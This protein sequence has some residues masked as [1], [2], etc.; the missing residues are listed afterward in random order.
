M[1]GGSFMDRQ[2]VIQ[3]TRNCFAE[4][5]TDR[6]NTI[7]LFEFYHF[8][9]L[10]FQNLNLQRTVSEA[11]CQQLFRFYDDDRNGFLTP[12]ELLD[13]VWDLYTSDIQNDRVAY[14]QMLEKVLVTKLYSRHY[15][16]FNK[17]NLFGKW[18]KTNNKG[19]WKNYRFNDYQMTQMKSLGYEF[20]KGGNQP[21]MVG[22]GGTGNV[23][24]MVGGQGRGG[25]QSF[26][27][28]NIRSVS[29]DLN[30]LA[31]C[32]KKY[33]LSRPNGN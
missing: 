22:G 25:Q 17:N 13:V 32:R 24:P 10:V 7:T 3:I 20:N 4:A 12:D 15:N 30:S 33:L 9:Q 6:S 26:G 29:V 31:F 1:Q 14:Q 11:E 8:L 16:E 2:Q 18:G 19:D 21:P 27:G 5:D 23:G 28:G